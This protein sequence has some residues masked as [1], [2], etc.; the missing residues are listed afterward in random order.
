MVLSMSKFFKFFYLYL[1]TI[2]FLRFRQ[3]AYRIKRKLIIR[4]PHKV[5]FSLRKK[6]TKW[7]RQYLYPEKI[8]LNGD[9]FFLNLH[10]KITLPGI[11]KDLNHSKLWI[12]NLHYFDDLLSFNALDK[13]IYHIKLLDSWIEYNHY[14]HSPGW[15]PYPTSLRVVNIIKANLNGLVINNNITNN[16]TKQ[17]NYLFKNQEKHLLGNHY[18]SNLKALL[19]GGLFFDGEEPNA[20]LQ[21][22]LIQ[23]EIEIKEQIHLD[24]A[25]FELSPMYHAIMLV[26]M[27]DIYNI[28]TTYNERIPES[29]LLL[30]KKYIN[31][32]ISFY[33]S[34]SHPDNGVAYFN[35][36]VDGVSPSKNTI[37]EY[38]K[39]LGFLFNSKK[40]QSPL[41]EM[42][43]HTDSGY[44][45]AHNQDFKFIFD[46]GSI[47]PSYIPGHA[48]ADSLSFELSIGAERVFV[49]SGISHYNLG[50]DRLKQRSTVSHNTVVVDDKN[51]SQV[52]HNF[53]VGNRAK[54]K[55]RIVNSDKDI[56][57]IEAEHDG[58]SSFFSERTH[59]RTIKITYNEIR[60]T[61]LIKGSFKSAISRIYIHPNIKIQTFNDHLRIYSQK[62]EM[63]FSYEGASCRVIE[64]SWH[65][66]F[67][68]TM[69]NKCI[70][71]SLIKSSSTFIASWNTID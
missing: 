27:L 44:F 17:L 47:G 40:V 23:L 50:L 20:W 45:V 11:W 34:I 12:Y 22:S 39:N 66:G 29:F 43:D 41:I 70:E 10:K 2:K 1:N 26:D 24:G 14:S 62:F 16:I 36:S 51:S 30:L 52:W 49:N 53:R 35:D 21:N 33:L 68:N 48:H 58:Y 55:K 9:S 54:I 6:S 42:N 8:S 65:Q 67:G 31:L 15:E 3:I 28:S 18:F 4:K 19:F 32:M 63:T 57:H 46:A 61:D 60:V 5:N 38:A 56:L 64:S 71:L 25:N 69:P 7:S 59:N 13:S 37:C